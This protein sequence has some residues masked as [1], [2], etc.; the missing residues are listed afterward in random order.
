M[1]TGIGLLTKFLIG[2]GISFVFLIALVALVSPSA[3]ANY[4][5]LSSQW[6]GEALLQ[7][8]PQDPR[9]DSDQLRPVLNY[10]HD[11]IQIH[12]LEPETTRFLLGEGWQLVGGV[13][14][15]I[16]NDRATYVLY[17]RRN[18][19]YQAS[20]WNNVLDTNRSFDDYFVIKREADQAELLVHGRLASDHAQTFIGLRQTID[21]GGFEVIQNSPSGLPRSIWSYRF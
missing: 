1:T 19:R 6:L 10:D 13:V 12:S 7:D 16:T 17:G 4:D 3:E 18:L 20:F 8:L 9:S 21:N 5:D 14:D 11:I 2:I 15:L